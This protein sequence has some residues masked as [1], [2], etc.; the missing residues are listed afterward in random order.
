MISDDVYVLEN[1]SIILNGQ[2]RELMDDP[3]VREAYL[4]I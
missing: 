1:G 4:G 2:G 3:R